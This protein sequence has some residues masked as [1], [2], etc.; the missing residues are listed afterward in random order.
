MTLLRL[1]IF[2]LLGTGWVCGQTTS[3]GPAPSRPA[4]GAASASPS[5]SSSKKAGAFDKA[6]LEAYLRYLDLYRVPVAYKIDDPRPS[7]E[8]PGFSEV[9]VHLSF[10]NGSKDELYYVS[11]DGK[12]ILQGDVYHLN[13]NPFQANLDKLKLAG[14]PVFGPANAPVTIVEFGDLECPDCRMESPLLRHNVPETFPNKVRVYF[15]DYPL[16]SIHPWARAAAIAGR[17]IYHQDAQSF[18]KFYDW[19][20]DNQQDI[21][22]DTL[23]AKVTGWAGENNLDTL[24]LDRCMDSKA[25]EAEVNQ[26]IAE[27]QGLELRG[28]PTLFINGRKIGGLQW[29]DLQLLINVEL[30]HAGGK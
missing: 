8:I 6:A 26:S 15:K 29:P 10:E 18:W 30:Q 3:S 4:A 19:I 25:T 17:C 20:Y 27:G 22:G 21:N 12:T 1:A 14:A 2:V 23:R 13:Q 11:A 9:A 7:K 28:T 16:E 24:Q 5:S